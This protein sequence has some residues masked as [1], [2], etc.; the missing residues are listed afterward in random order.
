ML[1]LLFHTFALRSL[2]AAKGKT[3]PINTK[4]RYTFSPVRPSA[5]R[6]PLA[7]AHSSLSSVG[8]SVHRNVARGERLERQ[9]FIEFATLRYGLLLLLP[10]FP[11]LLPPC[12]HAATIAFNWIRP[13]RTNE[14]TTSHT[15]Q[16]A[17]RAQFLAFVVALLLLHHF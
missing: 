13:V 9:N 17:P 6:R 10:Q 5:V 1:L 3:F 16:A 2:V 8:A 11:A 7:I 12:C 15:Q 14:F 4:I